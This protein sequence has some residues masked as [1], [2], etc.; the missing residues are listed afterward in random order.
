V[1]I[2][3]FKSGKIKTVFNVGVLT[4]GFDHPSLDCIILVRPTK[5]IRLYYQMLGRAVRICK[6]K[7]YGTLIDL[8]GTS[9]HIG[10]I[11]SI[12][13]RQI[14]GKWHLFTSQGQMDSKVLYTFEKE[15]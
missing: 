10:R 2:D 4:C 3:D 14:D 5:S 15:L 1:I 6:G 11:E 7:N 8:T 13:I 9:K 12:R